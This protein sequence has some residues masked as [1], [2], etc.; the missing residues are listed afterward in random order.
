MISSSVSSGH[1]GQYSY[2]IPHEYLKGCGNLSGK[3]ISI[4]RNHQP[5]LVSFFFKQRFPLSLMLPLFQDNLILGK[6][7]SSHFFRVTTAT[8]QLL[9]SG[10][11][12]LR[13]AAVFS[14]FRTVTFS[15]ELLFQNSFFFG[16]KLL[17]SRHFLRTK[18]SLRQLLLGTAALFGG[19]V[20]DE[21]I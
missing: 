3:T 20:Q 8:Q 21:D 4:K 19:T 16:V 9:F 14:F 10:S 18:S 5:N 13:T 15:Q 12:F 6:A 7:T 1:P 2:D 17:Q 11:Y